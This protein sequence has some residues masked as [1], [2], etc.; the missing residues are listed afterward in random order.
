ML[1]V[2]ILATQLQISP[3]VTLYCLPECVMPPAGE[4]MYLQYQEQNFP[5]KTKKKK[6]GPKKPKKKDRKSFKVWP[7]NLTRSQS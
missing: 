6:L 4:R 2:L 5:G 7:N 3:S 1:K